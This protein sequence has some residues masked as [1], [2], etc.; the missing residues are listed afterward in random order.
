MDEKGVTIQKGSL[1]S[2]YLVVLYIMLRI[3]FNPV[4]FLMKIYLSG[5]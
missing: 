5:F 2:C 4:A 1:Q 3:K